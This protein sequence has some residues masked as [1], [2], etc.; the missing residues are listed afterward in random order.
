MTIRTHTLLLSIPIIGSIIGL[1]ALCI[2]AA[3]IPLTFDATLI[4]IFGSSLLLATIILLSILCALIYR[5]S[6]RV[7]EVHV[8]LDEEP[9][10]SNV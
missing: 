4:V 1:I 3:T 6:S 8:I 7:I 2:I 10:A 9:T 5:D